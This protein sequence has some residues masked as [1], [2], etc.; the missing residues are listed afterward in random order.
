MDPSSIPARLARQ[1]GVV[2]RAQVLHAGD[3]PSDISRRLRRR[4]WVRVLPG[5]YLDHT[6]EPT[7]LQRCWVGVLYHWPA[8]LAGTTAIRAVVGPGW[9]RHDDGGP[10][11]LAVPQR[12]HVV[13]RPGF[14]ITRP[15][16]FLDRVH[17]NA[18]PPHLRLDHAGVD[19]ASR[20][21]D[22][23]ETVAFLA[24]LCQTRHTAPSRLRAVIAGRG[25]VRQRSVL[26]EVLTDLDAGTCSVLEREFL[27][28]VELPH[29]LLTP[30]R[31]RLR[32][33]PGVS[34]LHDVEYDDLGVVVELDGRL[35]HDSAGRRDRDL[36]RDLVAAIAGATTVRLGWGQVLARPCVTAARLALV[37]RRHGWEGAPLPCS[38]SCALA[39]PGD[40][41]VPAALSAPAAT[42]RAG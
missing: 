32:A 23:F 36:D 10:I 16:G 20:L 22:P 35:F 5:I 26:D 18:D 37:L 3:T 9:R 6:G 38:P 24:D 12:R 29:G 42:P 13:A 41:A 2:A 28:R 33:A 4:E 8:A 31:Q 27:H 39:E 40:H 14:L 11:E 15:S 34:A 30:S 7:W 1:S 17:W 21:R 19:V 25:K